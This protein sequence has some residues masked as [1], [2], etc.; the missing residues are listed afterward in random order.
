MW[1]LGGLRLGY[2]ATIKVFSLSSRLP[3]HMDHVTWRF[4]LSIILCTLLAMASVGDQVRGGGRLCDPKSRD[5]S[6]SDPGYKARHRHIQSRVRYQYRERNA[7]V[8][9]R[10]S[11]HPE[12]KYENMCGFKKKCCKGSHVVTKR[13]AKPWSY[14]LRFIQL[15]ER[16]RSII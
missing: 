1:G 10:R 14:C 5:L 2:N 16:G 9:C 15:S 11:P 4:A 7:M 12:C 13:S 6:K 3:K 8:W